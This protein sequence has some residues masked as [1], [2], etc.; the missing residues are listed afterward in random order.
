MT[1]EQYEELRGLVTD[2]ELK[3]LVYG[4]ACERYD[5]N[6]EYS[7]FP[8]LEKNRTSKHCA[9]GEA[10]DKLYKFLEKLVK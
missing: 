4:R 3:C 2:V 8:T 10:S 1:K 7:R 6:E 5:L 9:W